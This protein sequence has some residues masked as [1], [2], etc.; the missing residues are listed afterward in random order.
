PALGN[1]NAERAG[2]LAI[3]LSGAVEYLSENQ[4]AAYYECDCQSGGRLRHSATSKTAAPPRRNSTLLDATDFAEALTYRRPGTYCARRIQGQE[5]DEVLKHNPSLGLRASE[6][7]I[8]HAWEVSVSGAQ[9]PAYWTED[10]FRKLYHPLN[11]GPLFNGKPVLRGDQGEV[12]MPFKGIFLRE[13]RLFKDEDGLIVE[14]HK[15][16]WVMRNGLG[17][18]MTCHN[19]KKAGFISCD[20]HNGTFLSQRRQLPEL[21]VGEADIA[22]R[23]QKHG[24]WDTRELPVLR[25]HLAAHE[26]QH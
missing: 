16:V 2:W 5:F 15:G 7:V 11:G 9:Q 22:A 24:W 3:D 12:F 6:D 8:Q 21:W 17:R 4:A 26:R 13:V 23:I 25:A 18:M 1:I 20:P 14:A 19:L 10:E